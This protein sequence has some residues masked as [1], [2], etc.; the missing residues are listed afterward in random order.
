MH[1]KACT[2]GACHTYLKEQG[3]ILHPTPPK[4]FNCY[5]TKRKNRRRGFQ[6]PVFFDM[7]RSVWIFSMLPRS[8]GMNLRGT[9]LGP[10]ISGGRCLQDVKFSDGT[11]GYS[12]KINVTGYIYIGLCQSPKQH[13]HSLFALIPFVFNLGARRSDSWRVQKRTC[14]IAGRREGSRPWSW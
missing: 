11:G 1:T 10:K 8:R 13:Q 14:Q 3:A 9:V 12:S 6:N 4:R 2:R 7:P 5:T